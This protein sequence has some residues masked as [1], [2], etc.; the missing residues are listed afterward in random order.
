MVCN[1]LESNEICTFLD[2]KNS[3]KKYSLKKEIQKK[4][5]GNFPKVR[6]FL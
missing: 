6:N 4:K 3:L 1:G 5:I 2:F